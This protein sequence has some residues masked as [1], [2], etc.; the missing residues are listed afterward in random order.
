MKHL[1]LLLNAAFAILGLSLQS[2][3]SWR[4]DNIHGHMG[5]AIKYMMLGDYEGQFKIFDGKIQSK[6]ETDFTDAVF[7]ILIDIKS[8]S[9]I[10][11]DHE[12]ILKG[13]EFFDVEN[14]PIATF[15]STS[16]KPGAIPG[17]YDLQGDLTI[18]GIT[19]EIKLKVIAASKPI[20]NPYSDRINYALK[21]TGAIKRSD[22]G[23]GTYDLMNL[24]G[25]VLS[26]EVQI[27]CSLILQRS[28]HLIPMVKNA[29]D[30]V[31]EAKL[32]GYIGQYNYGDSIVLSVFKEQSRLFIKRNGGYKKNELFP[33]TTSKFIYEF[34]EFEIDFISNSSG[35][36]TKLV[37]I[38]GNQKTDA[39]KI[40]DSPET[41]NPNPLAKET[42]TRSNYIDRSWEAL[43]RK[44][45]AE[46]IEYC[47]AGLELSPDDLSLRI[48]LAHAYLFSG[49]QTKAIAYY[50]ENIHKKDD[51]KIPYSRYLQQDFIFF[52]SRNFPIEL[53]DKVYADLKLIPNDAYKAIR[54]N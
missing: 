53:L 6:S 14:F 52:K 16:M 29:R 38:A 43:I 25:L 18:R 36:I 32:T 8:V 28:D 17:T 21:I 12:K 44:N 30:S 11:E 37:A 23:I 54:S 33:L 31:D 42:L 39:Q 10:V 51:G 3:V 27:H 41:D 47:L 46:T 5:F 20:T 13:E 40:S 24:G 49:E 50:K 1:T 48:N 2:Q 45:Y 7:S 35:S 26:D 9:A 34:Y 22:Y 4:I 19:K 15:R